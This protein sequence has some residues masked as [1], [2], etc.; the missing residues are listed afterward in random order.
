MKESLCY[1]IRSSLPCNTLS[2]IFLGQA[3][4]CVCTSFFAGFAMCVLI[5]LGAC[6]LSQTCGGV[7]M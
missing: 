1:I 3:L 4:S 2:V 5:W 6:R 7:S